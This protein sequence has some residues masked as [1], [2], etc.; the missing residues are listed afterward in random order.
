MTYTDQID[1]FGSLL[2]STAV[3][4]VYAL[5]QRE[6]SSQTKAMQTQTEAIRVGV[7]PLLEVRDL[8][9][10]DTPP[11]VSRSDTNSDYIEIEISNL[12]NEVAKNLQVEFFLSS[13]GDL[14]NTSVSVNSETV[15]LESVTNAALVR[16]DEGG[17]IA[18]GDTRSY[19]APVEFQIEGPNVSEDDNTVRFPSCMDILEKEASANNVCLGTV[20]AYESFAGEPDELPVRPALSFSLDQ[21]YT[22]FK[23]AFENRSGTCE[24]D[25]VLPDS[26]LTK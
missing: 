21:D 15:P 2:L 5:Q 1:A 24:I 10:R 18:A 9:P 23:K 11:N 22:S 20:I 8:Q 17:V 12:G 3:V 25:D 26:I 14:A 19:W 16:E 7:S 13:D 6:L 4:I